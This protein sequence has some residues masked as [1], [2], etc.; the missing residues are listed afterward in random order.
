MHSGTRLVRLQVLKALCTLLPLS[1]PGCSFWICSCF[2]NEPFLTFLCTDLPGPLLVSGGPCWMNVS[3]FQ[4]GVGLSESQT[5]WRVWTCYLYPG[6]PTPTGPDP[7]SLYILLL[8][9]P[10]EQYIKCVILPYF[11]LYQRKIRLDISWGFKGTKK[12]KKFQTLCRI[13]EVFILEH[14]IYNTKHPRDI[15]QSKGV[16]VQWI[17]SGL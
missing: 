13:C 11:K 8:N 12:R 14:N 10:S 5:V 16:T 15:T 17:I 9:I 2:S 7:S 3:G 6:S 4:C 1:K